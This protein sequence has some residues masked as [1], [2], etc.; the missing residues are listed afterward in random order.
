MSKER[1]TGKRA[2]WFGLLG[3]PVLLVAAITLIGVTAGSAGPSTPA[4]QAGSTLSADGVTVSHVTALGSGQQTLAELQA[5]WTPERMAN[6]KPYP[7]ESSSAAS[8]AE[9]SVESIPQS[10]GS[11]KGLWQRPDGS[12]Q[13]TD[14][15]QPN[16]AG[17]LTEPYHGAIPYTQW[18]WFGR[19]LRNVPAG[20]PNLAISAVHKMFFTQNGSNFVCSS[21]TIGVDGAWTAGHCVSDGSNTFSTNVL[22]CPSYDNGINPTAGCWGADT[23]WTLVAWHTTGNLDEDMG[24]IDT[25]DTGTVNATQIG[26]FTGA[27]GFGACFTNAACNINGNWLAM[28]YPAAAPFG[29]G[30]IETC[31]SS[32][33]YDDDAVAGGLA[34]WAIGCDMTG[35][36]SGGPWIYGFGRNG[37]QPGGA[38]LNFVVGHNDWRHTAIVNELN[39]PQFNCRA[40]V[41]YNSINGTAIAC[42]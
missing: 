14:L 24:G 13:V 23:L 19:Y 17:A 32:L 8:S 18:Q 26:N 21:S 36:S 39:S 29:G 7:M 41:M 30:K 31:A 27:L 1:L 35:G 4:L 42:P 25:S 34:S 15:S 28:G 12:V 40:I 37:G 20:S 2:V 11:L 10:S 6:A 9:G 33:G 5:Y 22:V 16:S 3:T 38:A